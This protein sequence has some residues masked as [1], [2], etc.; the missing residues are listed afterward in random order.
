MPYAA[1]PTGAEVAALLT[2]AGVTLTAAQ[3]ALLDGFAAA[4]AA[5][6]EDLTDLHPFLAA[7]TDSTRRQNA[8]V[9]RDGLLRLDRPLATLTS[10]AYQPLGDTSTAMVSPAEYV[11]SPINAEADGRPYWEIAFGGHRWGRPLAYG[12][13][14]SLYVT[15]RWGY[16]T[17]LPDHIWEGLRAQAALRG[18]APQLVGARV[19]AGNIKSWKDADRSVDYG[20]LT[21]VVGAWAQAWGSIEQTTASFRNVAL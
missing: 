4:A 6:W 21:E 19:A 20:A 12:A 15:G 14:G 2:A 18:F 10:V 1:Y 7:E 5:T 13:R 9:T 11:G 8:P 16:T 3:E 17:V